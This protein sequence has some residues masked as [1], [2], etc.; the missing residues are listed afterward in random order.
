M[1]QTGATAQGLTIDIVNEIFSRMDQ[2]VQYR[3]FPW[4]RSLYLV[5]HQQVDGLFTIKK[6]DEREQ[7]MLFPKHP[8]VTQDYVFFVL[9]GS[10]VEFDG[11]YAS[12]ANA[13][14]GV[15]NRTS[16]GNR[17]DTAVKEN[18]FKRLD[19]A[20]SFELTFKKL[21]AG[22]MDTVICSR[23]VGIDILKQLNGLERVTISGPP[24]ETAVSYL[25]FS[26]KP[27]NIPLVEQF[28]KIVAEMEQDGTMAII[29]KK[30][31]HPLD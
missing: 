21:L 15:V 11:D 14:I 20:T 6:T 13:S 22:R 19:V 26:K 30:Y 1:Q 18:T 28:D 23:L 5:E 12:L 25:V 17:F 10:K 8:L 31:E 3:F 2:P 16:Y 24:S 9:K 4:A 7:T 29:L 27:E